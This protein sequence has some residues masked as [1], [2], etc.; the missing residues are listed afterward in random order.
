[1]Q[2]LILVVCTGGPSLRDIIAKDIKIEKFGLKVSEQKRS[3]R[4]NGWTKVHSSEDEYGAIN[5]Q[6]DQLSSVLS[7][8]IVTKRPGKPTVIVGLFITYLLSKHRK[9][10]Y[11]IDIYPEQ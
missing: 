3:S 5:I 8:R 11:A 2:D 1:M 10:I 9:Q 4:S 7:C 6:W